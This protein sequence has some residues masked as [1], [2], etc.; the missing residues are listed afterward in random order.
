MRLTNLL[1]FFC[2]MMG[3]FAVAGVAVLPAFA[4][5]VPHRALYSLSLGKATQAGGFTDVQGAVKTQVE[6]MCDA[7]ISTETIK[8]RVAVRSGNTIFQHLTYSGW[9][10]LDG[11]QYQFAASSVTDGEETR[12]RGRATARPNKPGRAYFR[13]P[14]KI[15]MALP[16]GTHFYFGL[17]TW[18][19]EQAEAGVKRAETVTFDGTD[20]EGPQ[21]VV[22]VFLPLK[23]KPGGLWRKFGALVDRPGWTVRLAFYKLESKSAAPDYEVE[24]VMLDNGVTPLMEMV[25]SEFTAIQKLEKIEALKQPECG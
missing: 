24:A 6:K 5:A 15:D 4:D 16:P 20:E 14:E 3:A 18:L 11:R 17:T 13:E 23:K 22:A 7:W 2:L 25:F 21:R 12:F 8:M 9:E 19:I 10:S 1:N